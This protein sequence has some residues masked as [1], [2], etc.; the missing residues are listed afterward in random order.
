MVGS[1]RRTA[2]SV[3]VVAVALGAS[4]SVAGAASLYSTLH[5][6]GANSVAQ[7]NID[8]EGR[9]VPLAP[10]T[11]GASQRPIGLATA[12]NGKSLYVNHVE[13]DDIAQYT[14]NPSGQLSAKNP[15][16]FALPGST[17]A[18]Q[19]IAVTPDS[20]YV[21]SIG[22]DVVPGL[23]ELAAGEGGLLSALT[24]DFINAGTN[25]IEVAVH[26]TLPKVYVA[27]AGKVQ[28]LTI[29][30]EGELKNASSPSTPDVGTVTVTPN[31]KY[32]YASPFNS[33]SVYGFKVD[34][35]TGALSAIGGSPWE[36]TEGA[37]QDIV[38]SNTN[39]FVSNLS[40]VAIFDLNDADGV[41]TLNG[42]DKVSVKGSPAGTVLAPDGK[43]LYVATTNG[44]T[45]A[46]FS[47]AAGGDL[48]AKSPAS[49]AI[50]G[51]P[52]YLA[53]TSVGTGENEGLGPGPEP[54]K[55][56]PPKP[57]PPPIKV[58]EYMAYQ[59][60]EKE[61][62]V[63]KI[64]KEDGKVKKVEMEVDKCY[65]PPEV[66]TKCAGLVEVRIRRNGFLAV[67]DEN[68]TGKA[69]RA[70]TSAK[71]SD[72]LAKGK[73]SIPAGKGGKIKLTVTGAGRKAMKGKKSF[74]GWLVTKL[75][76]GAAGTIAGQQKLTF[77]L[78]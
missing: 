32:L 66:K 37:A 43:S 4:A 22:F 33:K 53:V 51:Q 74:K 56:L 20:K 23:W 38:A 19:G 70:G 2:L 45:I 47:V 25:P 24:P 69:E 14:I 27:T 44:N 12:P 11:L 50:T 39:V 76:N 40:G 16:L 68:D 57:P 64:Y 5:L 65:P 35:T 46:Q 60:K 41:L 30:E 71:K 61:V 72:L 48:S 31:G 28:V 21:Y 29:E 62:L 6:K 73:F 17:G 15:F 63:M 1:V 36:Y 52:Q 49:V 59:Y 9:L 34:Q 77:K 54:P 3:A 75:D 42:Q 13:S 8:A 7:F 78:K 55:P 18:R 10:A 67:V 26:P 58:T